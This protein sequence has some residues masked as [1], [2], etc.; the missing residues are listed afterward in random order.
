MTA[1]LA[2]YGLAA[3]AYVALIGVFF[4]Q[5]LPWRLTH[6]ASG[7]R[8]DTFGEVSFVV[9]FVAFLVYRWLREADRD[10]PTK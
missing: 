8:T 6:F 3:W 5:S 9:S 10:R 7:P 1:T 2:V 4:P